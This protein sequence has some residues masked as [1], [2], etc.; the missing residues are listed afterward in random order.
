LTTAAFAPQAA[1]PERLQW[2]SMT[3]EMVASKKDFSVTVEARKLVGSLP[4]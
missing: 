4:R 1:S 2:F 3:V